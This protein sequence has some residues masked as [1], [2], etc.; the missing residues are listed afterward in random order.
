MR[1]DMN[2]TSQFSRLGKQ[3]EKGDVFVLKGKVLA[4]FLQCFTL[5]EI[6]S[7][8]CLVNKGW[9]RAIWKCFFDYAPTSYLLNNENQININW[10]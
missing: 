7:S 4:R 8:L 3:F 5:E 10:E 1:L 9:R 6:F 2:Y